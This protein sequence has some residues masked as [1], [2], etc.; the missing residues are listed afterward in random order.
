VPA[1]KRLV[2]GHVLAQLFHEVSPPIRLS[3][4]GGTIFHARTFDGDPAKT[5]TG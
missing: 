2:I 1:G 5:A 3:V 4:G